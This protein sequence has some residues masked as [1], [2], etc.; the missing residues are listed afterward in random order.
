M[1]EPKRCPECTS[2]MCSFK[3]RHNG[4]D[5]MGF[6]CPSPHGLKNHKKDVGVMEFVTI[7][8]LEE[9]GE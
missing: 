6:R 9:V 7:E 5:K 1:D 8:E 4:I 3:F 2:I